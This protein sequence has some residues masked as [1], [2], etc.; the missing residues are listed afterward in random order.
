MKKVNA[1]DYAET[2]I[3]AIPKGVLVTTKAEKVNSMV[4]GWGTFGT[5]WSKPMFVIY[6][7]EGRFTREQLDKNP[8]F[9]V[10]IPLDKADPKII[11]VSGRTSGRNVDKVKE[12]GLTLVDGGEISVPGIK[13]MPLTLECRV[14]FRQKQEL[15]LIAEKFRNFYP[16][17][18]DGSAAG[19]NKDAHIAYYGEVVNAY[20]AV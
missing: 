6:I 4:I 17:D 1:A 12:A 20:I 13:E 15:P 10:N 2:I 18:V 3:K 16:Q 7:R 11:K 8:E 5:E 19:A 9:T 14:V